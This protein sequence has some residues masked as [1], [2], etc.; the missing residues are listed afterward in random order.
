MR[1][2][3]MK[4]R[5]KQKD[6]F[7]YW[8]PGSQKMWDYF[9][10]HHPTYHHK[11]ISDTYLY[12]VNAELKINNMILHEWANTVLIPIHTVAIIP[13]CTAVQGCDIFICMYEQTNIKT[14]T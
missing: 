7:V 11:D 4:D 14:V 2:Y 9:M 6:F 1:L 3:W 13:K 8:K 12:M 5:V 10:K